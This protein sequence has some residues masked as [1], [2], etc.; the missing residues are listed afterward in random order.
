MHA[1]TDD[2]SIREEAKRKAEEADR[3][4]RTAQAQVQIEAAQ[5]AAVQAKELLEE[6]T[7]WE[8][9]SIEIAIGI[10]ILMCGLAI[11]SFIAFTRMKRQA[12]L[13]KEPIGGLATTPVETIKPSAAEQAVRTPEREEYDLDSSKQNQLD[14]IDN[15]KGILGITP[16]PSV[17]A[18]KALGYTVREP[19][20][21]KTCA[22]TDEASAKRPLDASSLSIEQT[23]TGSGIVQASGPTCSGN[24]Q[25]SDA[26]RKAEI[27]WQVGAFLLLII[28]IAAVFQVTDVASTIGTITCNLMQQT[29]P[30]QI[31]RY[32]CGQQF[33]YGSSFGERSVGYLVLGGFA[34]LSLEMLD[35][36][37]NKFKRPSSPAWLK[38]C[39]TIGLVCF[40]LLCVIGYFNSETDQQLQDCLAS[41][42]YYAGCPIDNQYCLEA[43]HYLNYQRTCE[44]KYGTR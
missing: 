28:S 14:L 33:L 21:E 40:L 1:I 31:G 38:R 8:T 30:A 9:T 12:A 39:I 44:Y 2:P 25:T 4:Q 10:T 32:L 26:S 20:T 19:E 37:W 6:R 3:E 18:L 43:E 29:G 34:A 41:N 17:G 24:G 16:G 23:A 22:V 42:P 27:T 35:Q 7:R 13:L 11:A 5:Q 36:A 15:K